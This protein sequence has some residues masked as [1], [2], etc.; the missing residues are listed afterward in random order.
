MGPYGGALLC[1]D[2]T[3]PP[4]SASMMAC[5]VTYVASRLA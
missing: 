4:G 1:S 3:L 2:P 5:S